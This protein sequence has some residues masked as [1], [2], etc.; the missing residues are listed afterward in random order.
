MV[1]K[2]IH[3]C[4]FGNN[5]M[6]PL[7][8]KCIKS[9]KIYLP[10]YEFRFWNE[11]T[12]DVNCNAWC[13]QAYQAKRYAFV[14]DYCRLIALYNEGGIYLDTDIKIC[15]SLNTFLNQNAFMGFEDGKVL[16]MGVIGMTAQFPI[17]KE[18]L[19]YYDKTAFSETIIAENIAN[20]VVFTKLL[21]EKYGLV[22]NNT[23]QWV[24]GIHI[25]PRTYFNPMDFFGN[26]DS[27]KHTVAIHLYMGSWLPESEQRK[28][29]FRKTLL[30]KISKMIWEQL[31]GIRAIATIRDYLK[32][33]NII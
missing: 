31:K 8:Q 29:R 2:I 17:L 23:E 18:A 9:W 4:W 25:Y 10:D 19:E 30:F 3:Y 22:R 15:K 16:S 11:E 28:V 33:K 21:E 32:K 27:S 24:A 26:W 1:P 20:V 6:P 5:E 12:F 13:S 14:A 7:V